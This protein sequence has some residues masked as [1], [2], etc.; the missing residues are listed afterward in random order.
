AVVYPGGTTP[1]L[2]LHE[3]GQAASALASKAKALQ[4]EGFTVFNLEWKPATGKKGIF[5]VET[6]QIEAAV[7]YVRAHAAQWSV[8]P[9]RL[10]M[11]GGS[12]GALLAMLVGERENTL[13]RGTVK[14][15]GSLSGQVNPQASI[16]RA[17]RGELE[18]VMTGTLAQAFGCTKDLSSCPEA[19]VREWSPLDK[20]SS[21]APAM[22]LA[23]SETE[24]RAWVPDQFE[25]AEAL[26]A[27]GVAASVFVTSSG[28]GFGYWGQARAQVIA[29][30]RAQA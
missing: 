11:L 17:R 2:L 24:H 7:S 25:T 3:K 16:E 1:L 21:S 15:V 6:E 4:R 28:H 13:A 9:S 8:D 10:V 23:A 26:H 20:V 22:L 18:S 5:P 12:R 14:A 29:F 19:Y 27:A 30:L